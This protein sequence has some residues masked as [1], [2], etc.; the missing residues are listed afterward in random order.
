MIRTAYFS[1]AD[2]AIVPI[3]DIL[4]L[5]KEARMN[6]PS[7]FGKNWT[8]RISG[9]VLTKELAAKLKTMSAESGRLED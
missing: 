5:G 4:G 7:T 6:T 3:Q 8:W 2:T 1:K 9:K